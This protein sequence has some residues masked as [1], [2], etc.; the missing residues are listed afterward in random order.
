MAGQTSA[1]VMQQ[2][3]DGIGDRFDASIERQMDHA[4][5]I[6]ASSRSAAQSA[7]SNDKKNNNKQAGLLKSIVQNISLP[8]PGGARLFGLSSFMDKIAV[9]QKK[10]QAGQEDIAKAKEF[11]TVRDEKGRFKTHSEERK[12]AAERWKA[13]GEKGQKRHPELHPDKIKE[14][15]DKKAGEA[16]KPSTHALNSFTMGATAAA[17]AVVLMTEGLRALGK[18]LGG[19]SEGQALSQVFGAIGQSFQAAIKGEWLNPKAVLELQ[20]AVGQE[21]GQLLTS[22]AAATMAKV[23]TD[24]G[25]TGGQMAKLER[26]F[27]ATA[28][29]S[30]TALSSF[31]GV[32]ILGQTA[33]TELA[34]NAGA[35][36]RAGDNF[37]E[38]IVQGIK[39]AKQLGLE[40][41]KMESTLT[42]FTM[43]FE[44]TVSGFSELRAVIPGMAT[45]FGQLLT[46]AMTGTTDEYV[47]QIRSSLLGAGISSASQMNRQ[48]AQLLENATGF[49]ADQIDRILKGENINADM[50]QDL[51]KKRNWLLVAQ[52]GLLGGILGA[53]ISSWEGAWKGVAA[54]GGAALAAG[55]ALAIMEGKGASAAADRRSKVN[56]AYI[57]KEGKT[58]PFSDDDNIL[59]SKRGLAAPAGAPVV[60]PQNNSDVLVALGRIERALTAG[61][62]ARQTIDLRG[63]QA[64][65]ERN[66]R[67]SH[68]GEVRMGVA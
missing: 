2:L 27:Q 32:G 20:G 43:D 17:T 48:Q 39:N 67:N 35:V 56:D 62:G 3:I 5:D 49:S 28:M 59:L 45:D 58:I 21:F 22:E 65:V 38:F 34:A 61:F 9:S 40:F 19:V 44:G 18:S 51:N 47:E 12:K 50:N 1:Q 10:F 29:D 31:A 24:F 57:T 53:T 25:I 14:R 8:L 64:F 7:G 60:P 54:V 36:A 52:V 26:T 6:A 46:T 16:M 66:M 55:S 30:R 42:G 68:E 41:S 37:N 63:G 23:A 4:D 15:L 11:G 13:L 33:A